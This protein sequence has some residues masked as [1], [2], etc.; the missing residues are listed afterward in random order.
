MNICLNYWCY[1]NFAS[2]TCCAGTS[3]CLKMHCHL[4]NLDVR[5][6]HSKGDFIVYSM[7]I[8]IVHQKFLDCWNCLLSKTNYPNSKNCRDPKLRPSFT[9]IMAILKPLQKPIINKQGT[10]KCSVLSTFQWSSIFFCCKELE[11]KHQ[12][13]KLD[14][15][16]HN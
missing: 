7:E 5:S 11:L 14:Q 8:T 13:T 2:F 10:W 6:Y 12:V 16:P 4:Y 15:K 1:L 3:S 9:E